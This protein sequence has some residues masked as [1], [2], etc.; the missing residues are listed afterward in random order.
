MSFAF[1]VW[2]QEWSLDY[3]R[4]SLVELNLDHGD[5]SAVNFGASATTNVALRRSLTGTVE[6]C[7]PSLAIL[8][9]QLR[10]D[11]GAG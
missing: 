1:R 9:R 11:I 7:R 10:L 2:R 5:V 8:R 3:Q 6:W 4:R